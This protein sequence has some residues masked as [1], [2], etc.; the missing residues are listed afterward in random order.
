MKYYIPTTTLNIDNILSTESISP[1]AYYAKRKFKPNYF[2]RIPFLVHNDVILLFSKVPSFSLTRDE[3]EQYPIVL[4]F[5][6]DQQIHDCE[7]VCSCEDFSVYSCNH[8]IYLVIILQFNP[9][10]FITQSVSK[11]LRKRR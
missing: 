9:I 6:D 4:E 1:Q 10:N 7:I 2:E 5:E 8:T 3:I 11:F